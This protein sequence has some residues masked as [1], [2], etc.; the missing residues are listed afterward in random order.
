MILV[1]L[2]LIVMPVFV[3]AITSIYTARHGVTGVESE[4]LRFKAEELQKYAQSQWTILEQNGLSGRPQYVEISKTA[5]AS[6]AASMIRDAAE[7]VVALD[8]SGAPAFATSPIAPRPQEARSLADMASRRAEGWKELRF[9]GVDRV[10]YAVSS[11]QFGWYMLVTVPRE[12]FDA[13]GRQI[14]L[15]SA[16]VLL[17]SVALAL[18]LLFVLSG[19]LTGPLHQVVAAMRGVMASNDLSRRVALVS[20]DETGELGH[21]FNLMT[22][23]LESAY[24]KIRNYALE[25]AIAK[26]KEQKIR[27]IFQK[28]V[29]KHVIDRFFQNPEEM[30]VGENRIL[31][32][33]FSDVRDFTR[34]S[35]HIPADEL[36]TM[37]NSYFG[38]L[39]DVIIG[40]EGVVD[41]YIGDA[42]MAFFGAPVSHGDDAWRAVQSG[43]DMLEAA[44]LFNE[45][46]HRRGHP[47][48]LM[49]VGINYGEVTIGNIGSEK[50]MDYTVVGEMVNL[51]SRLEGLTKQYHE[52][53][54]LSEDTRTA[55]GRRA[56]CRKLDR[57]VVKGTTRGVDIFTVRRQVN[58]QEEEGWKLYAAGLELYY[59]REFQKAAR[60]F[61]DVRKILMGDE[62][63]GR[64]LERCKLYTVNPPGPDWDG[65]VP[66]SE[67]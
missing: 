64:F 6:F 9:G 53:I 49:G 8:G 25:S 1:V 20:S 15:Q 26:K 22:G 50:K 35:E 28:Y 38:R 59:Q 42:V 11:P 47:A 43:F 45:E 18:A 2:P 29:P 63:A 65:V 39:V 17:L 44:E 34:I 27:S 16:V 24:N 36:V 61:T 58:A 30:L 13:A 60:C 51:A 12:S 37:L 19:Y 33:L 40:H 32:V 21:A 3:I 41:K 52:P 46:Q 54:I 56:P 5:V 67:K 66:I 57:V 4:F 55:I 48:F 7:L 10:G 14:F 31:A 62:A 23:E